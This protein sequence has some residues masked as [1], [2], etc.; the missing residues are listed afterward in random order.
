[1]D[2]SFHCVSWVHKKQN[3]WFRIKQKV[4]ISDLTFS[5][6][7]I[8][9]DLAKAYCEKFS[10]SFLSFIML[11]AKFEKL[12]FWSIVTTLN[13]HWWFISKSNTIK[14]IQTWKED[15]LPAA[16]TSLSNSNVSISELS[17]RNSDLPIVSASYFHNLHKIT[18][19]LVNNL[20]ERVLHNK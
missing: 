13:K 8:K 6:C 1:M 10:F 4:S 18:K 19:M 11:T 7:K 3:H 15:I 5:P 20:K 12:N 16:N 9:K 2:R 14:E 17:S